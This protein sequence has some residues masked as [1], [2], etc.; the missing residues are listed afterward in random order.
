MSVFAHTA[1]AGIFLLL[2]TAQCFHLGRLDS[3]LNLKIWRYDI[4]KLE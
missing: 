4:A 1:D 2:S 3:T